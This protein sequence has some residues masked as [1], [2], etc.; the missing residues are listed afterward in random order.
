MATVAEIIRARNSVRTRM[1]TLR[2]TRVRWS[3][4]RKSPLMLESG[5]FDANVDR[6]EREYNDILNRIENAKV[7]L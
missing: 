2:Y 1:S 5:E 3:G 7:V 6:I 4:E